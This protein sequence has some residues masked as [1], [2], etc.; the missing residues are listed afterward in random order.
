MQFLANATLTVDTAAKFGSNIGTSTF[1]GPLIQSFGTND[2]MN[3]KD[4]LEAGLSLNYAST[5]GVLELEQG[6][7]VVA[8]VQFQTSSLG[9][10]SFHINPDS[11]G[12]TILTHD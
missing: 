6:T 1:A 9:I 10:G 5:T 8:E 7:A 4:L 3:F 12:H 11:T 2:A